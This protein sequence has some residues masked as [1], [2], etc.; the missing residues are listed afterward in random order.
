MLG[1]WERKATNIPGVFL[2]KLP[3]SRKRLATIAIEVNPIDAA[4]SATKKGA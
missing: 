3:S 1:D 4:G 2:L